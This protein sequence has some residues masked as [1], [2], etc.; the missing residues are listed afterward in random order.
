MGMRIT[1][2]IMTVYLPFII[3]DNT[4]YRFNQ[5][6]HH[7]TQLTQ[8]HVI[9]VCVATFEIIQLVLCKLFT[10]IAFREGDQ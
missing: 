1:N 10:L 7:H 2:L 8:E 9:G 4:V 3:S 5:L 6:E